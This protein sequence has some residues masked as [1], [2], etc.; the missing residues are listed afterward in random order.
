MPYISHPFSITKL[1]ELK[2]NKGEI[3][4]LTLSSHHLEHKHWLRMGN[5]ETS[6]LTWSEAERKPLG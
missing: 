6:G 2:V 4:Y 5:V 1:V 3:V